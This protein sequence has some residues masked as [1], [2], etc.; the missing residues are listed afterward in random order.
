MR[1]SKVLRSLALSISSAASSKIDW[2]TL[3]PSGLA[4]LR[5]GALWAK[6]GAVA[7]RRFQERFLKE[8]FDMR[9]TI[10]RSAALTVTAMTLVSLAIVTQ[11]GNAVAQEKQQVSFKAPAKD[12][13]YE[14]QLNIDLGDVPNHIVRIFQ[15]RSAFPDNAPVI[16]GIKLIEARERGTADRNRRQWSRNQLLDVRDG[17]RGQVLC[18]ICQSGA[19]CR[20]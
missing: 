15:I 2:G 8:D 20:W 5:T 1:C 14:H 9:T 7:I 19:D 10:N 3:G 11:I 4:V 16:N 6:F 13:K 18:P 12:S 17:E